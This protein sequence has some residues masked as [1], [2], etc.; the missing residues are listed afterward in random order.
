[1]FLPSDSISPIS[2]TASPLRP[3]LPE[4]GA[5][6]PLRQGLPER[7]ACLGMRNHKYSLCVYH[8]RVVSLLSLS[9]QRLL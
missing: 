3:G 2:R 5:V 9:L 7:L 4:G 1:M 8:V 6:S